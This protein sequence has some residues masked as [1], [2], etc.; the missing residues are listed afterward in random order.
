M[1]KIGKFCL[2]CSQCVRFICS[3]LSL[4]FVASCATYGKYPEAGY[5][6]A[7]WYGPEFHGRPTSSGVTFN[8]YAFT[9]AHREYPFGT[10][11]KVTNVSN[12]KSIDCLVNDRGPFVPDRDLDL[13]YAA[14]KEIGLI[15]TGIC[16]VR[17]EYM[18]RDMTYIKEV[19][20]LSNAG[21]FTIQIGSFRE[22]SN[23]SRLKK[24]LGFKYSGVYVTEAEIDGD[25]FYRVRVGKFE[26]KEEVLQLA[27]SLAREG[28]SVFVTRYDERI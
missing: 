14:A 7:S 18:G 13:S 15:G 12:N 9:C 20:Y 22:L 4:L 19:K 2:S 21:P 10:K 8:M 3:V 23:A 16:K 24:A 26:I 1:A 6:V 17:I 28:Y 27:K 25:R 11:L 5:G